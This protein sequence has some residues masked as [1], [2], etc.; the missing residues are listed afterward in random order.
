LVLLKLLVFGNVRCEVI[1]FVYSENAQVTS[2][3]S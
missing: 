2:K 1:D 3:S